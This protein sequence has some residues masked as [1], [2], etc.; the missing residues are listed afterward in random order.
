MTD[1]QH[2]SFGLWRVTR[3]IGEQYDQPMGIWEGHIDQIALHLGGIA[4]KVLKF[5][6]ESIQTPGVQNSESVEVDLTAILGAKNTAEAQRAD[7]RKFFDGRPVVIQEGMNTCVRLI[8]ADGEE[9]Q[10]QQK[11][12]DLRREAYALLSPAHREALNLPQDVR[13]LDPD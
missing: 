5:A 3:D 11:A 13:E 7:A 1:V 8:T 10:K 6:P 2:P 9:A 12:A 4:G